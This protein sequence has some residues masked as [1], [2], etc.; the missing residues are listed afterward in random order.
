MAITPDTKDWTWVLDAAL[1]RVRVRP[2]ARRVIDLPRL[3]HDTA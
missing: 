1:S 2:A 3:I